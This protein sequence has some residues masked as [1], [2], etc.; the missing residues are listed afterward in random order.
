VGQRDDHRRFHT[1]SG[2]DADD[3]AA[4]AATPGAGTT[5]ARTTAAAGGVSIYL[6]CTAWG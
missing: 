6:C 5:G 2:E 3:A 1:V 4:D